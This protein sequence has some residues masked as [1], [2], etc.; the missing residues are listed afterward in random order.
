MTPVAR[1]TAR[2]YK[3]MSRLVRVDVE[4]VFARSMQR[5]RRASDTRDDPGII[6]ESFVYVFH[7]VLGGDVRVPYLVQSRQ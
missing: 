7:N 2:L 1:T 6:G 3:R 5:R 4:D